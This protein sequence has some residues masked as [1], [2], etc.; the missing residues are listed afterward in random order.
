MI[1]DYKIDGCQWTEPE[2]PLALRLRLVPVIIRPPPG[3]AQA[4]QRPTNSTR[5]AEPSRAR[6][7]KYQTPKF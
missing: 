3:F 7:N 6:V 5:E 2:S 1:D 4:G